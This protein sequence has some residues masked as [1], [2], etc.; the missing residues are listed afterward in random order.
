[1]NTI[2]FGNGFNRL[3]NETSWESLVHIIDDANDKYKLPNTLQYEGKILSMPYQTDAFLETSDGKRLITSDGK[4]LIVK[5]E[6]ETLLKQEIVKQMEAYHS[7]SIFDRLINLHVD[8]LM[9]TNYDYVADNAFKDLSYFEEKKE[10]DKSE[11]TFSI[12]RKMCYV[13]DT[14][15]KY[16]WK[17]HG[18]LSNIGSIMLGYNHYCNYVGQIKTYITGDYEFAKRSELGTISRIEDRLPIISN[19]IMSWIDLFFCS[20]IYIIGLGLYY[21]EMDLWW[22][23]TLRKR[24]KQKLGNKIVNN[25]I[26]FYGE[27]EFGMQSMLEHLDVHI[28]SSK[29]RNYEKRYTDFINDIE[30]R[31]I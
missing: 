5:E 4:S 9:T 20:D 3:N 10:R 6:S 18:E 28:I 14:H 16:L 7:N 21:D 27:P 23:L 13:K 19:D 29:R 8:H 2:L 24:L 12:H 25:K 30:K 26:L 11:R 1:M 17:I 15:K 31:I 22:V